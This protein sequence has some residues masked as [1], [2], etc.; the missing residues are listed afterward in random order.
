MLLT[1]GQRI[2]MAADLETDIRKAASLSKEHFL[3]PSLAKVI[4]KR[5]LKHMQRLFLQPGYE[6]GKERLNLFDLVK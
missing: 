5:V 6:L 4:T 3:D 1:D 2:H